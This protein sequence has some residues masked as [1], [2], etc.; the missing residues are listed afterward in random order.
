MSETHGVASQADNQAVHVLWMTTGL[1]CEGDSRGHDRPRR[2]RASRTSCRAPFPA[3]PRSCSTTGARLR[4]GRRLRGGLVPRRARRA[5]PVHPRDRRL[6][7]QRAD[8]RR[9]PLVRL[10]RQPVRRSADH[11]QRVGRSP[12]ARAAAV[13]VAVGTCAT[14]GGIPA[15]RNNP[16]GAMGLPDYLGWDWRSRSGLPIVCL[17][18]CPAQPDNMTELLLYLVFHIAGQAPAPELDAQLRPTWLFADDRARGLLPRRLHRAGHS[19][20]PATATTRA[21]SSSSAARVRSRSATC[22]CEAG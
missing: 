6:D 21:A 13:V 20:R 9:R 8:Q 1:S 22:P 2:A 18:G 19:S 7:R 17:P 16:T 10:R 3:C 4:D 14:Y 11:D 15:M 5:R 12:G